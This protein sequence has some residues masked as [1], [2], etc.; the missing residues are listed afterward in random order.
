[1]TIKTNNKPRELFQGYTLTETERAKFNY[2]SPEELDS[3]LFFRYKG[4]V[5]D[6]GEFMRVEKGG[7]LET[8]NWHG[9]RADSYFSGLVV[10]ICPDNE[11]VVVGLVLT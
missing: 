6:F 1:M 10:R 9:V 11:S 7:D 2:Y 4:W 3:A 5:Y 8:A